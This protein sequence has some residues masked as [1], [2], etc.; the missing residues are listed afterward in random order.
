MMFNKMRRIK[1]ELNEH[2]IDKILKRNTSGVLSLLCENGY[3][4]GVP[5]SYVYSDNKI[6]FHCAKVGQKLEA[7]KNCSKCS[8]TIIDMDHVVSEEY[9]TYFR[10]VIVF[11]KVKIIE[12]E[13]IILKDIDILAEKY[14]KDFLEER[15]KEIQ[16]SYKAMIILELEIEY[17]SGKQSI[18]LVK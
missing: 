10:S 3:P 4:Y 14:R 18:E 1:Q 8:F 9:T 17:K 13:D 7:I 12:E 16:K 11:G 5:L 2:E 6:I 15:Q